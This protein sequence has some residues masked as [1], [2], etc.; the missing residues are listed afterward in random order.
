MTDPD[1]GLFTVPVPGGSTRQAMAQQIS[2]WR[3][4][5]K[6]VS[7]VVSQHL[8]D[9]AH[10]VDL[11][12]LAGRPTAITSGNLGLLQLLKEHRL[13]GDAPPPAD[14]PFAALVAGIMSGDTAAEPP[15]SS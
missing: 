3:A 1:T 2:A 15:A 7:L 4:Q 5:G 11:A 8:L 10:A 9:Q 13:L 14:D 12:K 6:A